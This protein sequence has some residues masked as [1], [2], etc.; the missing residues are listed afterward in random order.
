MFKLDRQNIIIILL[1]ETALW[2][3]LWLFNDYLALLLSSIF[4]PIL[5]SVLVISLI[6]DSLEKSH[7]GKK[8]YYLLIASIIIP[9]LIW[10]FFKIFVGYKIEIF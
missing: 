7:V 3:F 8:Y 6:S 2:L 1:V 4:V 5:I 9:S 10:L